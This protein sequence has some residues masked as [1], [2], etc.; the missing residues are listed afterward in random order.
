VRDPNLDLYDEALSEL[1]KAQ[2]EIFASLLVG[3]LARIVTTHNFR[4]ALEAA[5][6]HVKILR[7]EQKKEEA[8]RG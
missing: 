7:P 6:K 3:Q 8:G 1:T 5:Q 4:I 2:R